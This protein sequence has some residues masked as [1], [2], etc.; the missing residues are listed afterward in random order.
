MKVFGNSN[1]FWPKRDE[2]RI[3]R[4]KLHKEEFQ[5]IKGVN[6]ALHVARMGNRKAA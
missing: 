3:Q 1:I 4:Y 6:L 2:R 5:D